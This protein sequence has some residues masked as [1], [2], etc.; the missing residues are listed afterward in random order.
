MGYNCYIY[1]FVIL[2]FVFVYFFSV[3]DLMDLNTEDLCFLSNKSQENSVIQVNLLFN[4]FPLLP[5]FRRTE[6]VAYAL[7]I[8]II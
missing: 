4:F 8:L 1:V 2:H 6:S 3:E 7:L 5:I